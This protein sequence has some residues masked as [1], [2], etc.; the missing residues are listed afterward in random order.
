M[1]AYIVVKGIPFPW[2][3]RQLFKRQVIVQTYEE[4]HHKEKPKVTSPG[5]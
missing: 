3:S 4:R 5:F 1:L 2:I